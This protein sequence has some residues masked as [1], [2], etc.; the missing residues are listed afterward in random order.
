MK[1][2][3]MVAKKPRVHEVATDF[4]VDAK[5]AL[6][7]LKEM[8]EFVKSPSSTIEP[9][10]A[11]KLR[12]HLRDQGYSPSGFA[13]LRGDGASRAG[14]LL[15]QLPKKLPALIELLHSRSEWPGPALRAALDARCLFYVSL[16]S[17][18][19]L[20]RLPAD[21]A[22]VSSLDLRSAAGLAL[23]QV[24][25]S[26]AEVVVW[27]P[28]DGETVF[29]TFSLE[30]LDVGTART[31]ATA[32]GL[33]RLNVRRDIDQFIGNADP[34]RRFAAAMNSM[35][36][37]TR[38]EPDIAQRS[39]RENRPVAGGVPDDVSLIYVHKPEDSPAPRTRESSSGLPARSAS[40]KWSVSG[41]WRNQWYP[42]RKEH[43]RIWIEEH[44]SGAAEGDVIERPRVYVLVPDAVAAN[45]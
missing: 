8:G 17:Y 42:G 26:R 11:R 38:R 7:V 23:V 20:I 36:S 31:T 19:S 18:R 16:Q 43:Q 21:E 2:E 33:R 10:V 5:Y 34:F 9:P 13:A 30:V 27:S 35:P 40:K 12:A 22:R 1:R 14:D 45:V 4:G 3:V 32:H 39:E 24:S 28:V 25:A 37:R 6:Q 44:T 41:H 29:H 15:H